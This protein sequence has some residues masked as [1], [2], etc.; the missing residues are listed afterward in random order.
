MRLIADI[1]AN[2]LYHE[3]SK[4][5]MI[6]IAE[7]VTDEVTGYTNNDDRRPSLQTALKRLSAASQVVWHNGIGYDAPV[8]KK[9]HGV[10]LTDTILDTQVLATLVRPAD[11][12]KVWDMKLMKLGKFPSRLIG[13]NSLEAWGLRL[14]VLK[15]SYKGSWEDFNEDMWTYGLQ[16]PVVTKALLEWLEDPKRRPPDLAIDLEHAVAKII[17]R[18]ERFGVRFD[19]AAAGSLYGDMKGRLI[20][21]EAQLTAAMG[22]WWRPKTP[23]HPV[24]N[25]G[26][27]SRRRWIAHQQG[28]EVRVE[29]LMG[30]LDERTGKP[31]KVARPGWWEE[32]EVNTEHTPIEWHEANPSSRQDVA[33]YLQ[34]RYGWQ[35]IKLTPTGLPEISEDTMEPLE[36][37]EAKLV[38]EYLEVQKR[39]AQLAEGKQAWLKLARNGRIH[40]RVW[41]NAANTGRMT[42]S[43]PNM[44]QAPG[45]R[46]KYGKEMRSLILP[47]RGHRMVGIDASSLELRPPAHYMAPYDGGAYAASVHSGSQKDGT[48]VHTRTQ[49]SVG[50][51]TR[52]AAK[53]YRY[54]DLYGAG[55]PKLGRTIYNDMTPEQ[56]RR[57]DAQVQRLSSWMGMP[58]EEAQTKVFGQMG[59]DVRTAD[60]K[61]LPALQKVL[62]AIQAAA[63]RGVI[64]GLDGRRLHVR[65]L[66]SAANLKFQSDGALLMKMA[67]VILDWDLRENYGLTPGVDYEFLLN[68]HDE[69]QL[70]VIDRD[71]LPDTVGRAGVEAIE[72]AGISFNYRC[73][74]TGEY[75]VGT[76]WS[77]TH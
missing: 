71:G 41:S 27:K 21:L 33:T 9:L 8:L 55:L 28:G 64:R 4:V 24:R 29:S 23:A 48:D 58:A 68:I 36:Y 19:E 31:I 25:Q 11:L 74:L 3:A 17:S 1:E 73:P 46:S 2:G 63:K 65:K 51:N 5:H 66:Y 14:G 32:Y 62:E 47:E 70:S 15:G 16:D 45:N 72:L 6:S 39:V 43:S 76:N 56:K 20:E 53:T 18:Q 10:D 22:G 12:L 26:K 75:K 38:L 60:R 49:K 52:A 61:A 35:P 40:G 37:P 44:A 69:W 67:L 34:R 59:K 13:S 7:A 54:A 30:T 50:L 57:V 77:E 42:H